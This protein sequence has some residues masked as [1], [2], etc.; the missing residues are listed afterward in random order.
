MAEEDLEEPEVRGS[1]AFSRHSG[2]AVVPVGLEAVESVHEH[3]EAVAFGLISGSVLP[4][5]VAH[6]RLKSF[7]ELREEPLLLVDGLG[8]G[9]YVAVL[10]SEGPDDGLTIEHN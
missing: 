10:V 6:G 1:E 3:I 8:S 9:G 2:P 5:S 4:D 7:L